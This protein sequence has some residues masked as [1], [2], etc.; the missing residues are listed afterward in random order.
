LKV[1]ENK[2]YRKMCGPKTAEVRGTGENVI[3]L[4]RW[5]GQGKQEIDKIILWEIWQV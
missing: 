5:C 2:E 1:I 3:F 4:M